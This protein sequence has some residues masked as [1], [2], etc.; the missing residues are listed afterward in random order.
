MPSF[1]ILSFQTS[2]FLLKENEKFQSILHLEI[3]YRK[4]KF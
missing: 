3:P 2:N 1:G 4:E